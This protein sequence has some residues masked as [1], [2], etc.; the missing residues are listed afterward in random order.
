MKSRPF[1][2]PDTFCLGFQIVSF[3]AMKW[4]KLDQKSNGNLISGPVLNGHLKSNVYCTVI[5]Q[6]WKSSPFFRN[7]NFEISLS[8][9]CA[10]IVSAN[11]CL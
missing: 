5:N 1:D 2:E 10:T 7:E 11:L 9:F 4:S 8:L 3:V 6:N